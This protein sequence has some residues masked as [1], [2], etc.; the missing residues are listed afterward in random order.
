MT[1]IAPFWPQGDWFPGLLELLSD[2][3][4][5]LPSRKDLL[6][7][8]HFHSFHQNLPMLQLTVATIKRFA[9]QAGFSSTVAGQ[10]AFFRRKSTRMNYQ[11]RWSSYGKWCGEFGHRSSSPSISEIAEFLRFLLPGLFSLLHLGIWMRFCS[12]SWVR[13]LRPLRSIIFGLAQEGLVLLAMITD[14]R[15][16][17]SPSPV[18]LCVIPG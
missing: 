5:Q 2:I 11:A 6:R 8:P 4:M 14:K 17:E 7:Q 18:I 3:P 16:S 15:V 9:R 10:L 1:L 13:H 12:I